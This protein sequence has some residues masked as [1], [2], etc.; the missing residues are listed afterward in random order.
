MYQTC[1]ASEY[2]TITANGYIN[3]HCMKYSLCY[4]F[5]YNNISIYARVSVKSDRILSTFDEFFI[6]L[7][8]Q[9]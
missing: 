4:I 6:F 7:E 5:T 8:K 3:T 2:T 1:K 9:T